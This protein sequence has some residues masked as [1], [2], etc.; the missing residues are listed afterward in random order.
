[1]PTLDQFQ[2]C[3]LGQALGDALGAS[4]EGGF[5]E[6]LVWRFLGTT[7]AGAM[8]WTDD[9]QMT[10]DLVE[11]YLACGSFDPDDLARRFAASY[12]WDR[13][14]GPGTAKVLKRIAAGM[15]WREANRS[16]YPQGS[17]GNGAAMRSPILGLIHA[18]DSAHLA[19]SVEQTG[20][21]THAH[22]VAL[23]GAFLVA[24]ATQQVARG[25]E[26]LEVS[27]R[28]A[29][30]C[31]LPE[32][33]TRLAEAKAWLELDQEI[34]A[35]LVAAN[36]G[37][38]IA[39]QESCVTALYMGLRYCQRPFEE[40]HRFAVAVGGDVDTIAAMAGAIWGTANG[41]AALPAHLLAKL[42]DREHLADLAR[43]LHRNH[44]QKKDRP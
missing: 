30:A 4:H 37:R 43:A 38:G 18:E 12:R 41:A 3:L 40:M 35:Q 20:W 31:T 1:M 7:R 14:Y 44:G 27:R 19:E 36:L 26:A 39:A 34:P 6:R 32:Y 16:V 33:R 15:D 13:G 22:P 29:T 25:L 21:I 5:L 28:V 2:G 23:E 10:V 9:T 42:E 17:F 8:R 11:S 24:L